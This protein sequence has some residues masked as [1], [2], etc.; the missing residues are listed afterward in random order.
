MGGKVRVV[1][2]PCG[3]AYMVSVEDNGPGISPEHQARIFER[4]FQVK[5][6]ARHLKGYGLGLS[7]SKELVE[8]QGGQMGV[9]SALGEGSRFWI[10]M[11]RARK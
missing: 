6:E 1:L 10:K 8:C 7:I 11:P 4:R 9:E 2:E 3:P 5:S